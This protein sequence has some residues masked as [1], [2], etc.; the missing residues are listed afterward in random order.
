M[1]IPKNKTSYISVKQRYFEE[2]KGGEGLTKEGYTV[3]RIKRHLFYI[4]MVVSLGSVCV[5]QFFGPT[6]HINS[7]TEDALLYQGEFVWEKTDGTSIISLLPSVFSQT[8][9]P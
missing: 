1:I 3:N 4:L 6:E 2:N 5:L 7:K 8:N 9:S